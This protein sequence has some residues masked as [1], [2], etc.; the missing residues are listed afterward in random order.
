MLLSGQGHLSVY[1][2]MDSLALFASLVAYGQIQ[3]GNYQYDY[4]DDIRENGE[5]VRIYQELTPRQDGGSG[6]IRR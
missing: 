4:D 5:A 1:T 3:V 2:D 6:S